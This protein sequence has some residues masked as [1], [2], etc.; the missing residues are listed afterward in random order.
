MYPAVHLANF[1]SD[2]LSL[3]LQVQEPFE[4]LYDDRFSQIY[5]RILFKLFSP[6][7]TTT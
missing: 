3:E 5:T 6:Q 2:V 7:K 1:I 4:T